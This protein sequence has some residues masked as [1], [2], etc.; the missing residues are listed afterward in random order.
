M[1]EEHRQR[2]LRLQRGEKLNDPLP[3]RIQRYA[4]WTWD[5]MDQIGVAVLLIVVCVFAWLGWIGGAFG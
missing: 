3:E 1:D 4:P 2:L 5:R